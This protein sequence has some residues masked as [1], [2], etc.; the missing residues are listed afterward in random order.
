MPQMGVSVAEGTIVEWKK[1]VGDAVERDEVICSISTD[2]IDTDVEAPA[3]RHAVGDPRRGRRD[4]RGRHRAG[5]IATTRSRRGARPEARAAISAPRRA[6]TSCPG[7]AASRATRP[8]AAAGRA[9]AAAT[10]DGAA[11]LARR[12]ADRRRARHRPRDDRGH[13][14]QRPRAQAGRAR[15]SSRRRARRAADAHRVALQA[16][17][18]AARRASRASRARTGRPRPRARRRRPSTATRPRQRAAL[19]HAPDRSASAMVQSL[20][21]AA[22]CTTIVEVDLIRVETR[23]QAPRADRAAVRGA[24]HDRR[25]CASSR[26]STPTLEGDDVHQFERVHLGIAVSLGSGG[27][28]VPVIHNAQ[29][30]R[31]RGSAARIKE[32]AARARDNALR[33]D[34]VARRHVHDHQPGRLR[35]DHRHAGHQ[36]AAGR[37]PRHRGRRQAPGRDTTTARLDRDPPDGVLL[38]VLGPPRARR[39][40]GGAVPQGAQG[41]A[42]ST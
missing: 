11:L 20:Q 13:R 3:R 32:L 29:D 7:D 14:P 35:L 28:I 39:R 37:D 6:G 16:R 9:T 19:A 42:R 33:P 2:K 36:P 41:P 17:R 15:R 1:A 4:G 25:R 10:G 18:A 12:D 40:A 30:S 38:H 8:P 5:A 23:A 34:D 26:R 22:T 31:S 27:L 21:T 24:R